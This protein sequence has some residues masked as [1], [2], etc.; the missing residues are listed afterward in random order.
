MR[1]VE[2]IVDQADQLPELEANDFI[3]R[4]PAGS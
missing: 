1:D 3:S 4:Q 2:K